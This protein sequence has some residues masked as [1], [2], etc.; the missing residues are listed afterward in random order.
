MKPSGLQSLV[1]L[2]GKVALVTGGRGGI[3][4]AVVELLL[5]AGAKVLSVDLPGRSES[6]SPGD[7][8]HLSSDLAQPSLVRELMTH[9][10]RELISEESMN[11]S[12]SSFIAPASPGTQFSGKWRKRRG[13]RSSR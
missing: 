7:A 3:G 1:S 6:D 5:A 9:I 11:G 8:I 12:T 13:P 2:E 4:S 10:G